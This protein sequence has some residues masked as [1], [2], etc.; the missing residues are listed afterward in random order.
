MLHAL[1]H[2]SLKVSFSPLSQAASEKNK[3]EYSMFF[4]N[5][6]APVFPA[7]SVQFQFSPPPRQAIL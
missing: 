5:K 1:S 2:F 4:L 7:F 3:R 6:E